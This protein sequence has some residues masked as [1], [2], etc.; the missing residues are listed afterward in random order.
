M[1]TADEEAASS[2][3]YFRRRQVSVAVEVEAGMV[4]LPLD[5]DPEYLDL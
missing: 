1:V 2:T 4:M 3:E 5:P